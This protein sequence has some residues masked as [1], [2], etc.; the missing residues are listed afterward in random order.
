MEFS[1]I[2]DIQFKFNLIKLI[3]KIITNFINLALGVMVI[4][5]D[6]IS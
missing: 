5:A 1:W 6:V 3:K 2:E 4:E